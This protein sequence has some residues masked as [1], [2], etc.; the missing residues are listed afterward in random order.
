M[1]VTFLLPGALRPFAGGQ[2]TVMLDSTPATLAE[3]LEEL[4]H[5]CPGIRDR[6]LTEQSQ[7]RP[8][9]N[10][11]VGKEDI[12]HTGGLKTPVPDGAE[13]AIIPAITGGRTLNRSRAANSPKPGG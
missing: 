11:F 2:S 6:L 8:H 9:I 4:W 13:I 10:V 3:A 1:P 7:I 12:R 5:C